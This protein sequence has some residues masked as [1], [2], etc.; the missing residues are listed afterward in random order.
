MSPSSSVAID[1]AGSCGSNRSEIVAST[2]PQRYSPCPGS[3][4]TC[5]PRPV[6]RSANASLHRA[7]ILARHA[8]SQD[9][10]LDLFADHERLRRRRLATLP[11]APRRTASA[12]SPKRRQTGL[13]RTRR[14]VHAVSATNAAVY[15]RA[16][17]IE[18]P[19]RT[20]TIKA[21]FT[22]WKALGSYFKDE[23]L[24]QLFGRYATYVG[25]SPYESPATLMLIAD[26]E[27]HGSVPSREGS[28]AC[29]TRSR[30]WPRRKASRSATA[31]PS[32]KCWSRTDAPAVFY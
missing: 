19:W 26:V 15:L 24:R 31:R 4:K 25:S 1:P 3:S 13:Q 12:D 8:W 27:S 22:L 23:R 29:R 6:P 7:E 30:N 14:F 28:T 11:A 32:A 21:I 20:D 16:F 10:R 2:Q 17:R 5:L 18:R 9:E